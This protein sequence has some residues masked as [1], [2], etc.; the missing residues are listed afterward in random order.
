MLILRRIFSFT[1]G[2]PGFPVV[3][4][5]LIAL[6]LAYQLV[7]RSKFKRFLCAPAVRLALVTAMMLY[8]VF[9][10]TPG[11]EKFYYFRF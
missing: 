8:L 10:S 11:Y 3:A 1:A 5:V 4:A 6:V 7:F 9:F 2:D